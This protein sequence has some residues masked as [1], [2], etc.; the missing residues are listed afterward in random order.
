MPGAVP[1]AL[2]VLRALRLR[3]DLPSCRMACVDF[4]RHKIQLET[5]R[6]VR[7]SSGAIQGTP[8]LVPPRA[9]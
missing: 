3:Q 4:L 7:R 8:Q 6:D 9:I 2:R 1:L 5:T